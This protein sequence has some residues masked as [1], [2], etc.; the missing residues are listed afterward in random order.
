[1]NPA[2]GF[3]YLRASA[4]E[5]P[6]ARPL[7]KKHQAVMMADAV[8]PSADDEDE[9]ELPDLVPDQ[10]PEENEAA[11]PV[12]DEDDDAALREVAEKTSGTTARTVR[13]PVAPAEEAG[14][15]PFAPWCKHCVK[16]RAKDDPNRRQTPRE[17]ARP[18]IE[19]D[20]MFLTEGQD[21]LT[22]AVLVDKA[23]GSIGP[24]R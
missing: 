1:M 21:T 18:V 16:G 14:H 20:Y 15:V 23:S 6:T 24:Q 11:E 5:A 9:A 19:M 2:P 3:F 8:M 22:V 12:I 17:S 7:V 10:V 13:Q 4:A